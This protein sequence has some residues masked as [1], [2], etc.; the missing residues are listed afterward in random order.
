VSPLLGAGGVS[1]D[2]TEEDERARVTAQTIAREWPVAPTGPVT[3]FVR[4]IGER[5]AHGAPP[6]PFPWSFTVI[7][8]RAANAFS[9]GG[10][11][12][13]VNE[14]TPFFCEDEAELAA[15]L[16]H[17]MG[18]ELAGH[19]RGA[20]ANDA[21]GGWLGAV[22][23]AQR[24]TGTARQIGSVHQQLDP[25]REREADRISIEILESAGYDPH[26]ALRIAE[27]LARTAPS[28]RPAA[29][30]RLQALEK[31]LEGVPATGMRDTEA[32]RRLKQD[33]EPGTE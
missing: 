1:S 9:I 15:I 3:R 8:N 20:Y 28:S 21:S 26:A 10:G 7:R 32:F 18:H 4:A 25:A 29:A 31:L 5:L 12:I 14:G 27:R 19:F 17:E 2:L 33:T 16:A 13:Y 22:L 6:S 23:G 11:R 30:R 24:S